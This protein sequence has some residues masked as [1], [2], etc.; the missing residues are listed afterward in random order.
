MVRSNAVAE[1]RYVKVSKPFREHLSVGRSIYPEFQKKDTVMT[2]MRDVIGV[3]RDN[4]S[5][6]ARHRT[7]VG[8]SPPSLKLEKDLKNER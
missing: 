3:T 4:V 2:S 8:K 1:K 5:S 7:S 6:S